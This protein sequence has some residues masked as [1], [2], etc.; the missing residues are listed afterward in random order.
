MLHASCFLHT[1]ESSSLDSNTMKLQS[2]SRKTGIL[3]IL[4]VGHVN[5]FTPPSPYASALT[6][7]VASNQVNLVTASTSTSTT[8]SK[9]KYGVLQMTT[10]T[11]EGTGEPMFEPLGVGIKRDLKAR[12]PFYKSDIKDGL[13]AQVSLLLFYYWNL[14]PKTYKS[15][16]LIQSAWR[17]F[18]FCSLLALLLQLDLEAYLQLLPMVPLE[19]SK[20]LVPQLFVD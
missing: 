20:W 4:S 15:F 3:L 10:S 17:P 11:A 2:I 6:R 1:L 13:N 5:A 7:A 8:S 12:L 14:S 18:C 16:F 19:P 9:P